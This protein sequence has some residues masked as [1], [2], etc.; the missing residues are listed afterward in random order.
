MEEED[1]FRKEISTLRKDHDALVTENAEKEQCLVAMKEESKIVASNL[2][3]LKKDNQKEIANLRAKE[4]KLHARLKEMQKEWLLKEENYEASI[5]SL[6]NKLKHESI[7][8]QNVDKMV[9]EQSELMKM[10]KCEQQLIFAK[11]KEVFKCFNSMKD[12]KDAIKRELL[13]FKDSS[14]KLCSFLVNMVSRMCKQ[15][16]EG[17]ISNENLIGEIE[18]L[19]AELKKSMKGADV[20]RNQVD[21]QRTR[22]SEYEKECEKREAEIRTL[23]QQIVVLKKERDIG[24]KNL[25]QC[26]KNTESKL[27]EN[28]SVVVNYRKQIEELQNENSLI[29]EKCDAVEKHLSKLKDE[30][31]EKD[32]KVSE[33]ETSLNE[34][35]VAGK[36]EEKEKSVLTAAYNELQG[37][38]FSLENQ[39]SIERSQTRV[40]E[41]QIR[42]LKWQHKQAKSEAKTKKEELEMLKSQHE[43]EVQDITSLLSVAKT[44][45]ACLRDENSE[46][47]REKQKCSGQLIESQDR[48]RRQGGDLD[49]LRNE[50]RKRNGELMRLKEDMKDCKSAATREM[51]DYIVKKAV[52]DV[53]NSKETENGKYTRE[54]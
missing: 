7:A 17:A 13:Q 42:N 53:S 54:L 34:S 48:L 43:A 50:V 29:V 23:K 15:I 2:E 36:A 52:I 26:K 35:L 41:D 14:S 5:L 24:L 30:A 47:R 9:A 40:L 28:D 1:R 22:T 25:N 33:L 38:I 32:L 51:L 21:S 45:V 37:V 20:L 39:L 12:E 46:I 18:E 8:R 49:K 11:V 44:E 27:L 16:E 19:K 6:V 3:R 31:Q 10:K 4:N